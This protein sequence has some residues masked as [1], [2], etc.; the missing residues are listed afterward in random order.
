MTSAQKR[1]EL[2]DNILV[3]ISDDDL[4]SKLTDTEDNFT[5]RKSASDKGGWLQ[6]AVAFANSCPVGFPAILYVGVNNDGTVQHR[7]DAINFEDLQKSISGMI[8]H[9][10]PPIYILPKTLKKDGLEFVAVIIP[11]SAL[12]PH[13]SGPAWVRIGPETRQASE[14]QF[15]ELIAQRSS[16]VRAIRKLIGKTVVWNSIQPFVANA[17]GVVADCNQFFV[18][19]ESETY[20]RCFPLDWVNISFEPANRR[21]ELIIHN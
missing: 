10:W 20:T 15:D 14:P 16:K 21:Y 4:I 11:G 9:A 6:T 1:T 17:L 13:F 2:E 5:E 18:T 7:I 19:I 12:R 8:G 3:P